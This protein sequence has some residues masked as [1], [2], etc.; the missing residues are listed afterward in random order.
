MPTDEE[1]DDRLAARAARL[2]LDGD[3]MD[4]GVALR[5]LGGPDRLAGR[6]RRHLEGLLASRHGGQVVFERRRVRLEDTLAVM[7]AIEDLE[8]RLADDRWV[9]RGV[10][11][12]GRIA[13]GR[14]DPDTMVHL[15]QHG[16]RPLDQ[17]EIELQEMGAI[18]MVRRSDRT[19][20][21]VISSLEFL[22]EGAGF[23]CRR[24]P[25]NQVPLESRDLFHDRSVPGLD[26]EGVRRLIDSL[27]SD[28][29]AG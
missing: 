7:E 3:A 16:D 28:T 4:V 15:R 21:G 23:R 14:F 9:H 5:R 11:L 20:F 19:R 26:L 6:A 17:L 22:Y 13:S 18:E 12:A 25:P 2:V 29:T 10:R 8:V 27:E 1:H 24:C